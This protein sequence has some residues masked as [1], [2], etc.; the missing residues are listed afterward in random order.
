MND[1]SLDWN[2]QLFACARL[3]GDASLPVDVKA[4][5]HW[6]S[7]FALWKKRME[8]VTQQL[9]GRAPHS[10]IRP[11]DQELEHLNSAI[12]FDPNNIRYLVARAGVLDGRGDYNGAIRDHSEVLRL[13]S[14]SPAATL[15]LRAGAYL[16]KGDTSRAMSDCDEMLRL[17]PE[18]PDPYTCRGIVLE[19][20]G[21]RDE[22]LKEY[23]KALDQKPT[24]NYGRNRI[25]YARGRVDQLTK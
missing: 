12:R 10:P 3:L 19:H 4:K 18:T 16:K 9:Q 8:Q 17:Q 5:A 24:D 6:G 21:K 13:G 11:T 20:T 7:Y 15:S 22:A 25:D 1:K 2:A 23:R 14:R